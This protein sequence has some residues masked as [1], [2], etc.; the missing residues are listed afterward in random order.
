M[1]RLVNNFIKFVSKSLGI[2]EPQAVKKIDDC[3]TQV[4]VKYNTS[5]NIVYKKFYSFYVISQCLGGNC[6][7]KELRECQESCNCVYFHG[8]CMP[9]FI[10]EAEN[11]N[12]DP[13]KWVQGVKTSELESFIEYASYLYYNYEGGGLTDNSFDALEYNLNKRLKQRGKRYEK[14]GADPIEKIRVQLPYPMMSLDKIKPNEESLY[15]FIR[16]PYDIVWSEKLDGVSGMIIFKGGKVD[17]IYT[18][19]NGTIGG[20]VS[21]LKDYITLPKPSIKYLVV[22]GEFIVSKKTWN[23]KYKDDYSNARSFVS[24]KINSGYVTPVVIDIEFVAYK[25]VDWTNKDLPIPSQGFKILGAEG[26]KTPVYGV[27]KNVLVFDLVSRYRDLRLSSDYYIDGLVLTLDIPQPIDDLTNPKYTKAFKMLLEDQLRDTRVTN[28]DWNITRHGRY[29]PVAVYE[30]VYVDGVRLHR[31]S[32]HNAKHVNDW[33]LGAGTEITV[34][35][36]GDV[37]P[38]IKNVKVNDS[39]NPIFPGDE[40]GWHWSDSGINIELDDIESNPEVHIK[41]LVHFFTTIQTPGVGEG[42]VKKLYEN[43]FK[44]VEAI[45]HLSQADLK[46][47][48]GF[49]D[50]LSKTI[51]ENIHKTLQTTRMDRFYVALSTF[52][53]KIGRP[54]MKQVIREYPEIMLSTKDEIEKYFKTH[55]IRGIGP[56]RIVALSESI[57]QFREL[58]YTLNKKDIEFALKYHMERIKLFKESGLNPLIN[59]KKFVMTG[60]MMSTDYDLEDYIWDNYGDIVS[61]VTS[62]TTAVVSAT[63]TNITEKM[64]KAL[65]LGIPVYTVKEFLE[66]FKIPLKENLIAADNVE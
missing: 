26:F 14:I 46:K 42:R 47:I 25:I 66:R 18:R 8:K 17:K 36:S 6:S 50:K 28:V 62:E 30:S 45:T 12:R 15:N 27:L 53:S 44:T 54:L 5:F 33:R 21:Y 51:Y 22:R 13:D 43:G 49:G 52:K 56:A 40:Y 24:A 35:R 64:N 38:T 34:A 31:A 32:A 1:E 41:R 61:T 55:K 16:T 11:I 4:A 58:L 48:K 59:G 19:G 60:F 10:S 37:I 57:P 7:K 23:E 65:D 9:R 2:T 63:I 20:D 3:I 39:I 29:F